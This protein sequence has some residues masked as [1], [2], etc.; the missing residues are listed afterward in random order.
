MH[1][2][3]NS[4]DGELREALE[5]PEAPVN[6][7]DFL[8]KL[9]AGQTPA[10]SASSL[11]MAIAAG[12]LIAGG[13]AAWAILR[14]PSEAGGS[15]GGAAEMASAAA[16]F[17]V[18]SVHPDQD[19]LVAQSYSNFDVAHV[20]EGGALGEYTLQEVTQDAFDLRDNKGQVRHAAVAEW[21]VEAAGQLNKEVESLAAAQ[22]S[23]ALT[24]QQLA[25]VADIARGGRLSALEILEA[26]AASTGALAEQARA[27]QESIGARDSVSVWRSLRDRAL[28]GSEAS[29]MYALGVL[30]KSDHAL[31]AS[32]LAEVAIQS[33]EK[34]AAAAVRMLSRQSPAVAVAPLFQIAESSADPALR[35]MAAEQANALLA[36]LKKESN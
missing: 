2:D 3:H 31:A 11:W 5:E 25:R 18:L 1:T 15:S 17:Q 8:Q 24:P 13:A 19:T 36:S 32:T 30:A 35:A 20:K 23:G 14:N 27:A 22:R 9:N 16:S 12:V 6:E 34:Y 7:R 28:S 21:N 10:R 4:F 26:A 29:R 33:E